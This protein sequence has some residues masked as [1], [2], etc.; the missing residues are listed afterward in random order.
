MAEITITGSEVGFGS[1]SIIQIGSGSQTGDA[2]LGAPWGWN[3]KNDGN[4]YINYSEK[5]FGDPYDVLDLTLQQAELGLFIPDDGG[6]IL[7]FRGDFD[8]IFQNFRIPL[9]QNNKPVGPFQVIFTNVDD[10]SIIYYGQSALP[11]FRENIFT[12]INQKQLFVATPSMLK[13][14]YNIT[15]KYRGVFTLDFGQEIEVIHRL[16]NDKTLSMR[17]NLPKFIQS[18]YKSDGD[19]IPSQQYYPKSETN[20]AVLIHAIAQLFNHMYTSDYTITTQQFNKNQSN[21]N[22][23]STLSFPY[24]GT[25]YLDDGQELQYSGKNATQFLNVTG[26]TNIIAKETRVFQRNENI[27]EI[28]NYYKTRNYGFHKPSNNIRQQDWLNSFNVIEFGERAS[29][30][31]LFEYLYQLLKNLNLIKFANVSGNIIQNP[32]EGVWNTSHDQRICKIENNFY[33]INQIQEIGGEKYL[34]LDEIG[35][36]YWNAT[37][38]FDFAERRIEILPW[39]ITED[40]NGLFEITFETT[41]FQQ[42]QGFI[43]WNFVDL[44]IYFQGGDFDNNT[45]N[46]LNLNLFVAGGVKEKIN[47][48]RQSNE[49]FG[50]YYSQRAGGNDLIVLPDYEFEVD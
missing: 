20:T 10:S 38:N 31:V 4:E 3:A 13:G 41:V 17:S 16:R 35:N 8:R 2:G 28:E 22:V 27:I 12:N 46:N 25:I 48:V 37:P 26:Q 43:D 21:L 1:P 7:E 40:H 47:F 29:Q 23:E 18:G 15:L 24:E 32:T 11:G 45:K 19:L 49:K 9:P 33:F 42:E 6:T 36:T 30:K 50:T 39:M 14:T 34:Y 5:G 44:D